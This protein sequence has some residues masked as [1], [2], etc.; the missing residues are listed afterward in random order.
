MRP[1]KKKLECLFFLS[2]VWVVPQIGNAG[3]ISV[4]L[5]G[6]AQN[7]N[8][9]GGAKVRYHVSGQPNAFV[10]VQSDVSISFNSKSDLDNFCVARGFLA[11]ANSETEG[12]N[13]SCHSPTVSKAVVSGHCNQHLTA[14]T[15]QFLDNFPGGTVV[16][17]AAF[18]SGTSYPAWCW[19]QN[20][21]TPATSAGSAYPV[22]YASD[23]TFPITAPVNSWV[24]CAKSGI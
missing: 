2:F 17:Y 10:L 6:V 8:P 13:T 7:F 4:S 14:G 23:C 18:G 9:Y 24:A 21:T 19:W 1:I 20:S 22:G 15:G 12:G 11:P 16:A 3:P 5:S